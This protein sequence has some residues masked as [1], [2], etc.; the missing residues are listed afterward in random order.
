MRIGIDVEL[1]PAS[2]AVVDLARHVEAAGFDLLLFPEHMAIPVSVASAYKFGNDGRIPEHYHQ[3]ADPFVGIAMAAA[4]TS[5]LRLGTGVA[6]LPNHRPVALAK[7]IASLDYY[8][9]GRTLFAF[10][11][12]WLKEESALHGVEYGERWRR[13]TEFL[14]A[15]RAIWTRREASYSGETVSFPPILS[16]PKPVQAGGPKVL[17]GAHLAK[18]AIPLVT[19]HFD[20]WYPLVQDVE[21]FAAD[22]EELRRSAEQ[23]GRDPS[24][25]ILCPIVKVEARDDLLRLLAGV[26]AAGA[27]EVVLWSGDYDAKT[28]PGW[29]KAFVDEAAGFVDEVHAMS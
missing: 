7:T 12:G 21:R 24:S 15:M 3:W 28:R 23:A 8:S 25:V 27:H 4:V 18:R 6:A 19:S 1:T 20:G 11:A 10:G 16:E 13:L 2:G 14:E 9:G 17:L 29:A 5:R 26:H 22:A